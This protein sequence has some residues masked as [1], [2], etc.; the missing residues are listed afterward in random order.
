[1]SLAHDHNRRVWDERVRKRKAHTHPAGEKDFANPDRVINPFGWIA[2][3]VKGKRVLCLA[4]GGAK[5]GVLFAA[6]GANVTV[7]DLSPAMLAL[8]REAAA[9]RGLQVNVVEASMDD[10]PLGDTAFDIV[11]QPVSACYVPDVLAV[12]REVAR[13]IAPGGLYIVQHKQP[14]S[15]Q[16]EAEPEGN[17]YKLVTPYYHAG[18]LAPLVKESEHRETGTME[19]LHRLED[20]IGGLCR[21]GFV[22]EDF[23][24]PRYSNPLAPPGSFGHRSWFVPPY[25]TIKARRTDAHAPKREASKLWTP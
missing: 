15:L 25:L 13:V 3:G 6:A 1:M 8:D 14:V 5:H 19:F 21:S 2:G 16:A 12:Y 17:S 18:P 7:V 20:L 9:A 4:A 22:I 23:V 11:L 10:L 24:E